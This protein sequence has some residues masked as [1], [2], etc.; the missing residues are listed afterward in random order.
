MKIPEN[1]Y[2][3]TPPPGNFSP[4]FFQ[5]RVLFL[6]ASFIFVVMLL[7]CWGHYIN[8]R[9][10]EL[11]CATRIS[12]FWKQLSLDEVIELIKLDERYTTSDCDWKPN[13]AYSKD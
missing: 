9:G 11:F 8:K 5:T 1:T 3:I 12:G 6:N 7:M 2:F 4:H 13:V 10:V